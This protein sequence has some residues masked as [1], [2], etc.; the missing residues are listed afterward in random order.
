MQP[1]RRRA[2]CSSKRKP[3][4]RLVADAAEDARRIVDER[5]VVEH[6]EHA[7]FEVGATAVR[8][9]EA[10]EVIGAEGCRHGVDREVAPEEIL[11]EPG[12]LHRRQRARRVVELGAG[13]DDVDA[14]AVRVRHDRGAEPLVRCRPP[15]ERACEGVART[16][17]RLPRPRCRRRS[18]PRREG[19]RGS[20][21]RRRRRRL[22]VRRAAPLR[23]R[24]EPGADSSAARR[25]CFLAASSGSGAT[26]S[27]ARR[28]SARLTTPTSS[29]VA[30][31]G[32][33]P[34]L[35]GRDE[36]A[37][38]GK[39]RVLVCARRHDWS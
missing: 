3:V 13:R 36:R 38:L 26:P 20:C 31:H 18:S 16:R 12:A 28:R 4:A 32:D 7:G 5:E 30:K 37:Q 2:V 1:R 17:S 19:C 11:A 27:S 24:S 33:T 14:L 15:A 39:G 10:S 34:V 29:S 21:R 6:A 9:D 23:R 25:R 22:H 8:V 35:R